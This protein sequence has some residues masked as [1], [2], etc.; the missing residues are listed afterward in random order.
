M[1]RLLHLPGRGCRH[2]SAGRC[3]YEEHINPGLELE[4]RCTLLCCY[5]KRLDDFVQQVER[6]GLPE[7][8][9]GRIWRDRIAQSV[10]NDWECG[11]FLPLE[12]VSGQTM[13][14]HFREGLCLLRL[15]VC[16]GRCRR[17]E[18]E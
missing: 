15:P 13:C 5:E 7:E 2:W 11:D 4:F 6:F 1:S 17:F 12:D 9:A 8:E 18:L 10:D 16:S 14:R 3:L